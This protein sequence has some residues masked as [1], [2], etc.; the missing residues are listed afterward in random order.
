MRNKMDKKTT[1]IDEW[2]IGLNSQHLG[3]K[4]LRHY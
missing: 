2:H 4:V 1:G 3:I